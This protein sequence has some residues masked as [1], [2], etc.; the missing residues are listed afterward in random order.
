MRFL[1]N[2]FKF[3]FQNIV[4]AIPLFIACL[5]QSIINMTS[6]NY[7]K[8]Q[9]ILTI[10]RSSRQ[11]TAAE[12]QQIQEFLMVFSQD[13]GNFGKLYLVIT[14][15]FLLVLPITFGIINRIY[16]NGRASLED[17]FIELKN[18]ILK[19][20]LY[21]IALL[22]FIAVTII[23]TVVV[24]LIV[25]FI[26]NT[27]QAAYILISFLLVIAFILLIVFLINVSIMGYVVVVTE[28]TG[29]FTGIS[30]AMSTI[31]SYFWPMVGV[32]MLLGACVSILSSAVVFTP[33][34]K[35]SGIAA[36][37]SA[38][39]L[40]LYWFLLIVFNFEVYRYVADKNVKTVDQIPNASDL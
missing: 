20:I 13:S 33:I 10:L 7:S 35:I 21:C 5:I 6:M 12:M 36:V 14:I 24:L 9:D 15:V 30:E 2:S 29:V 32:T 26:A 28:E 11:P 8:L 19:F 34:G 27:S 4:F 22:L 16:S 23:V 18:N 31:R 1:E 37:F 25:S 3:F 38:V 17:I 39:L 40:T